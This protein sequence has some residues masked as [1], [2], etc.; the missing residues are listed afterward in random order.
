MGIDAHRYLTYLFTN[1]GN[2][3]TEADWDAMLP[4]SANLDDVDDH[5]AVLRGAR[6]DHDRTTPYILR[7]KRY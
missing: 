1:E 2:C 3:R 5:F 6:P 7:G 4:V